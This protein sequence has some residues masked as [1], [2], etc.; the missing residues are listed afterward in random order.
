M[1][2]SWGP[3]VVPAEGWSPHSEGCIDSAT[4]ILPVS[5]KKFSKWQPSANGQ[6]W[7]LASLFRR[8]RLSNFAKRSKWPLLESQF[9]CSVPR[10]I[11]DAQQHFP[12]A[13]SHTLALLFFPTG[14]SLSIL[15]NA[16]IMRVRNRE[17]LRYLRH[18]RPSVRTYRRCSQCM[19]SRKFGVGETLWLCRETP[20]LVTNGQNFC[21]VAWTTT[22]VSW[23]PATQVRFYRTAVPQHPVFLYSC[24]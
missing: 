1:A 9:C 3:L 18:V 17:K 23:L 22:Y 2:H 5:H 15:I 14:G 21:L 11:A 7:H 8:T 13:H 20:Y 24:Q 6:F 10:L 12:S 4:I 16:L 19:D